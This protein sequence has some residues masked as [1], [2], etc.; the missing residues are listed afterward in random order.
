MTAERKEELDG[1]VLTAWRV[2]QSLTQAHQDMMDIL[3]EFL[4]PARSAIKRQPK[5][6]FDAHVRRAKRMYRDAYRAYRSDKTLDNAKIM[7]EAHRAYRKALRRSKRRADDNIGQKVEAGMMSVRALVRPNKG[8]RHQA[9][10][11]PNPEVVRPFWEAEFSDRDPLDPEMIN[12][13]TNPEAV[14]SFTLEDLRQA[15]S[16]TKLKKAPGRDDIRAI[17]LRDL[18]DEAMTEL[19]RLLTIE[20]NGDGA[21]SEWMTTGDGKLVYKTKGSRKDPGSYRVVVL[22]S[23]F[24]KVYEKMLELRGR[25]FIDEGKMDIA[26]EQGGFMPSRATYDSVFI[27]DSLRAAQRTARRPLY[28]AFL[29]LRKAFDSVNHR[30]LLRLMKEKGAPEDWVRQVA[31][32]LTN[33]KLHLLQ[34]ILAVEKGTA[35]GSPISPLLFDLFINPLIT[36]L[37]E[38][39]GVLFADAE[40]E[41]LFIRSLFFADDVCLLAESQDDLRNML[42]ICQKWAEDFGM[43]FNAA[44]CEVM[45]LSGQAPEQQPVFMIGD[46]PIKWVVEFR[47]LGVP[48]F[49]GR[50]RT[51]PVPTSKM[52]KCYH[53]V[54]RALDPKLSLPLREQ[55][56][57][58][59]SDI[60]GVALY[61]T[62]VRDMDY[63]SIDKFVNRILCR[64]TASSQRWTSAT[65]LRTEL[66]VPSSRFLAHRR[67]LA[68]LWHLVHRSWFRNFLPHL[69][70]TKPYA[71]LINL[72]AQYNINTSSVH[73]LSKESWKN[74]V[75]KAVMSK[76]EE[77]TSQKAQ[78]KNLPKAEQSMQCRPYVKLGGRLARFGIRYRWNILRSRH[79]SLGRS[80][81]S[82]VAPTQQ[83]ICECCGGTHRSSV[84]TPQE[85]MLCERMTPNSLRDYRKE[86]ITAVAGEAKGQDLNS[87]LSSLSWK[88]QSQAVTRQLLALVRSLIQIDDNR[89]KAGEKRLRA[90]FIKVI[91]KSRRNRMMSVR[92]ES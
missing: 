64:L 21:L 1:A 9:D 43:T 85:M 22:Q 44:K 50:K 3:L 40:R 38:C 65:F 57:L 51:V 48:I 10:V 11:V 2:A 67:E 92:E 14:V 77:F 79:P 88:G 63:N 41:G 84:P 13:E 52:W 47:Y 72:A 82:D 78:K 81:R 87:V 73:D 68:Y 91:E 58:V 27:L 62:A 83:G 33:R 56:L 4:G 60:L 90:F 39:K 16:K 29:D 80:F 53:R 86:V 61:P 18:S 34:E 6:W 74:L 69:R 31:K 30:L 55:L 42:V 26:V 12:E 54:K 89:R 15:I 36:R 66:G 17:V 7:H 75:K 70:G 35:Q 19:A 46:K 49:Q 23:I 24:S 59:Q 25:A 37:R 20:A 8:P 28:A 71:R 5:A 76:A 32:M 45:Q